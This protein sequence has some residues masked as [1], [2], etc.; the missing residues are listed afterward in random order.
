MN[1]ALEDRETRLRVV[2]ER[3]RHAPFEWGEHDCVLFAA[4]CLDAQRGDTLLE[5]RLRHEYRYRTALDAVRLVRAAG[6]WEPLI[7]EFMGE[8]VA[9]E[10]L[11]LGDLVL[12]HGA[13]GGRRDETVTA[14]GVCDEELFMAPGERGL[15]WLPMSYALRG[16]PCRR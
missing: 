15:A 11:V 1:D 9:V 13:R 6:G 2:V 7:C 3:Y 8:S 12:G 16:W 5:D 4:R 10:S 14:L